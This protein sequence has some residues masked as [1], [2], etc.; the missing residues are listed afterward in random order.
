MKLRTTVLGTV[1]LVTALAALP[2][3]AAPD[4][5]GPGSAG[6]GDPYFPLAG[7]GGYDVGHYGLTLGYTRAGNQLEGSVL[8]SATA[9]QALDRFDL[10]LRGF[11]ISRLE[12]DGRPAT[13]T[14]EGQELQ[15]TPRTSKFVIQSC[16]DASTLSIAGP[17]SWRTA[18]IRDSGCVPSSMCPVSLERSV[19]GPTS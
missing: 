9:T 3:Q 16:T 12:V 14:R 13:F 7:N 10:D 11:E 2:A 18:A 17:G 4:P 15:I 5:G 19:V 1:A 6:I 8:I